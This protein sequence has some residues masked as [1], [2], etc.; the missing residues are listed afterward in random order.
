MML[1]RKMYE[2]LLSWKKQPKKECILL[3]GARQVGKTFLVRE[4]GRKEYESFIEIN[5]LEKPE[6]KTAFAGEISAQEIYKRLTANL[7]SIKLIPGKTLLFLDEIQACSKARMALK[8]LSEDGTLDVIASGS[9]LGLS[10]GRDDDDRVERVESVPVGYEKSLMMYPLDFEEYLWANGFPDETISYLKTYFSERKPLSFDILTKEENLLKEYLVVGGMPEVVSDFMKN[11]DFNRVQDIQEK[12]LS[13]Y[14]DDIAFH[15]KG[16]EKTKVRK[17]FDSIPR[18]LAKE[19]RKFKYSEVEHKSTARKYQDSV[20]WLRDASL[21]LVCENVS[22]PCLPLNV[23][24]KE[25]EF[26]VYFSDTGLLLAMYGFETKKALLNDTLKGFAK[27]GIYENFVAQSLLAKGYGLHYYKPDDDSELE[28]LIEK[29]GEVRPIEVKAGNKA[30]VSL[31]RF[32]EKE[33]PQL[34]Y[35]LAYAN[36]GYHEKKLTIPYFMV[37]FL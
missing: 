23:Y 28:F 11:H 8:F 15:A 24:E 4:F 14:E 17:C 27:G 2:R 10:Y 16:V 3:K 1:K 19:N 6:L 34:V 36:L 21:A 25:N 29:D 22:Q 26:K 33:K 37:M 35:K 13:S 9:L 30:T 20:D 5:F 7:P 31:N 32:L 18:Q 12:I